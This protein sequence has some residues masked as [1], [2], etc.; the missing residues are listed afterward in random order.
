MSFNKVFNAEEQ[1]RLKEIIKDGV[2]INTEIADLRDSLKET[3]KAIAE[4]MD[5]TPASI[6]KAIS[7]AYRDS[8][9][10]EYDKFDALETILDT[11]GLV[12][13]GDGSN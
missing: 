1:R 12:K 4:E 10:D 5:I 11:C 7:V 8:F 13:K 3:V 6:N 2:T 9:Q